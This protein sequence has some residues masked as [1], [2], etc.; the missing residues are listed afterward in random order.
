MVFMFDTEII[1]FIIIQ[2]LEVMVMPIMVN[3]PI[4]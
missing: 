1:I 4:I 2:M 3:T